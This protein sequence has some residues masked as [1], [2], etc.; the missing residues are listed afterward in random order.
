MKP[1]CRKDGTKE[2]DRLTCHSKKVNLPIDQLQL[3]NG[4]G[5]CRSSV[6]PPKLSPTKDPVGSRRDVPPDASKFDG[7]AKRHEIFVTN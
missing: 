4:F 6:K 5:Q 3:V 2:D 1:I 7:N